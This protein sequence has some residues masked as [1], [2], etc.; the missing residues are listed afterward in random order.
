DLN[1]QIRGKKS[2]DGP[3]ESVLLIQSSVPGRTACATLKLRHG[4]WPA[5]WQSRRCS[6]LRLRTRSSWH[7]GPENTATY[8]W[9][10]VGATRRLRRTIGESEMGW[11]L[12]Q[13]NIRFPKCHN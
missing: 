2:G 7:A 5:V 3:D 13:G 12:A 4:P 11:I 1:D 6:N 10:R 9:T 8:I